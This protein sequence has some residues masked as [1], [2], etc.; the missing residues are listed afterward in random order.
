MIP[1]LL[2]AM[3]AFAITKKEEEMMEL[4]ARKILRNFGNLPQGTP[5]I[6]LSNEFGIWPIKD[7]ITK[8]KLVTWHRINQTKSNK[9]IKE[10]V[11]AQIREE[12]PWFLQII[13][14]AHEMKIDIQEVKHTSK[15]KWKEIIKGKMEKKIKIQFEKE[16]KE[17]ERYGDIAIDEVTPGEPKKYMELSRKVASAIFRGR[18]GV[19]DPTPRKP[20]WDR[21]WR[22]KFCMEKE[23]STR[24]YILHCPGTDN[25][26]KDKK[27][28]EEIFRILQT[29]EGNKNEIKEMG[30]KLKKLYNKI[31][32]Q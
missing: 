3:G 11:N 9:T 6:A 12:L 16:I 20:Y 23:R 17:S 15:Q 27:E 19:L 10:V 13:Q 2:Y 29:L 31:S 28:R 1:K 32:E 14:I 8:R 24:H 18:A 5:K 30:R 7:E 26:F 25:I 21:V 4:T 22:C